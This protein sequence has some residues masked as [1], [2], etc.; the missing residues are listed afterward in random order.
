ML[1]FGALFALR[2]FFTSTLGP[3]LFLGDLSLAFLL[4]SHSG[5]CLCLPVAETL[6]KALSFALS[7]G[8]LFL[9]ELNIALQSVDSVLELFHVLLTLL[10]ILLF[11]EHNGSIKLRFVRKHGLVHT[12]IIGLS[13][14][15][16]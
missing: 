4:E 16:V 3:L 13:K 11:L 6:L 7:L 10:D 15:A 9:S 8:F 1:F 14:A 2:T 5:H 12:A